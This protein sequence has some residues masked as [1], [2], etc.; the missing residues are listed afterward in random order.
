MSDLLSFQQRFAAA[1][2]NP[3]LV[4]DADL[5]LRRALTVHR[6]TESSNRRSQRRS[7]RQLPL[8]RET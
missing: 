4:P 6:N 8:S 7:F 5:R 3:A 2:E 1:L